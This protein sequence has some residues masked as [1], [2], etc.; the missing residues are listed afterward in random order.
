MIKLKT[1]SI[2][3]IYSVLLSSFC[4]ADSAPPAAPKEFRAAWVATVCNIDWPSRKGLSVA[5]QKA[6]I[7][8]IVKRAKELKLNALILQVR[9][10]ADA[11]YA[12]GI[13]P[14]SEF[15][16]GT[17][18]QAPEPFYDPLKVWI[19]EAHASA[20][21]LHAWFNPYRARHKDA[22]SPLASNHIALAHPEV[23]KTYDGYLW[24][25]PSEE[26]SSQRTIDVVLDVVRRY[27][28]DGVH[29]DDY[30]YP[31]PARNESSYQD[32]EFPDDHSWQHYTN[33]GGNLSRAD[34][35]RECVNDLISRLYK[36]VRREK[37]WVKVGISPFGIGRPDRLPKGITG[38]S[39]YDKIYAHPELW[40]SNGWL[41][42]FVPQL[43]WPIAQSA[44]AFAVLLNYWHAQNTQGR[45]LWPGLF[46]SRVE[47]SPKGWDPSEILNQVELTRSTSFGNGHVHF[48]FVALSQN[49]RSLS[50]LLKNN[51]YHYPA[52]IPASR[53]LNATAPC[54]P[55]FDMTR[56]SHG[57]RISIRE[58]GNK[59][60]ARFAVW[61]NVG[62]GWLFQVQSGNQREF[63]IRADKLFGEEIEIVLSSVDRYG[64]EGERST[65]KYSRTLN[66]EL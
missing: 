57:F 22:K 59:A 51:T 35:R 25:D 39:Q 48:S 56:T 3:F 12:S 40:L 19:D 66:D 18:G 44:Q 26:L 37:A 34:W 21:E 42:Y 6:E 38:F 5:E 33:S 15:L 58:T 32:V 49:R 28:V 62:N 16:T 47:D 24:M 11:I 45:H 55:V 7:I 4:L 1:N 52:L 41:D 61:S 63:E 8:S 17:Q 10:S 36:A 60:I 50:D 46:S 9:P 31:Y 27:D 23:V 29:L 65:K 2:I 14:W 64:N 13:E 43:Y 20:I 54:A 53:W 30:F